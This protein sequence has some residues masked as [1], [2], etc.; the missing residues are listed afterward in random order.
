MKSLEQIQS[1]LSSRK[2]ELFQKYKVNDIA[3][4]GSFSRGEANAQSDL[5]LLVDVPPSIGIEFIDLADELEQMIG[6]K[7]GLVSKR[8]L[9]KPYFNE[10]KEDLIYV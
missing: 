3:I 1:I 10:I 6:I 8:G 9:K 2:K 5:D 7:I 4:F